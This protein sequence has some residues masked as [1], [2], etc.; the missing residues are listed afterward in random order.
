MVMFEAVVRG[1][2]EL[3]NSIL[4]GVFSNIC[5]YTVYSVSHENLTSVLGALVVRTL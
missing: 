2:I 3:D 5:L 4:R 1:D